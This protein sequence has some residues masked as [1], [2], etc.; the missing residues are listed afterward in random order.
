MAEL[1][2][3]DVI[4]LKN[5]PSRESRLLVAEKVCDQFNARNFTEEE[6][7]VVAEVFRLL[8]KDAEVV[9]RQAM[10]EKLKHN[11]R[12]PGDIAFMLANDVMQ[13]ALPILQFS[14]ALSEEDLITIVRG[15]KEL[16]KL[17]A[18]TQ[19]DVVTPAV[20]KELLDKKQIVITGSLVRNKGAFIAADDLQQIITDYS[21]SD[22]LI[23]TLV[24]RRELPVA[25]AER[26]ISM[27]TGALKEQ[28]LQKHGQHLH[29]IKEIAEEVQ[30]QIVLQHVARPSAEVM[31]KDELVE[32][33]YR[34]QK[35]SSSMVIRAIC[36]G[37]VEFFVASMAK[38]TNWKKSRIEQAL[39]DNNVEAIRLL[40]R[41]GGLPE[42]IQDATLAVLLV[43][44]DELKRGQ[45]SGSPVLAG[46]IIERVVASGYD[47]SVNNMSYLLTL[48]GKKTSI[49]TMH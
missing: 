14:P 43:V 13:V 11:S 28:L 19:R 9:I 48:V 29:A 23:A 30:E 41:A 46:R 26:L 42:S 40:Y 8:A 39:K 12:L 49:A 18:V 36:L 3:V 34:S 4:N 10:A 35:L 33:L 17:L 6:S 20:S 25:V 45:Q 2:L 21:H 7:I 37:D 1:S 15:S 24:E 38:L 16:A 22:S 47:R 31:R 32:H 44:L 27:V 5:N